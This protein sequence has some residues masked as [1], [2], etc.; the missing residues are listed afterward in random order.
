MFSRDDISRTCLQVPALGRKFK[1]GCL[2]DAIHEDIIPGLHFWNEIDMKNVTTSRNPHT[3]FSLQTS[4]KLKE[5]FD[6]LKTNISLQISIRS[7]N[8]KLDGS[9]ED[10][11]K[12]K[13]NRPSVKATLLLHTAV[14]EL[15]M[16]QLEEC[17]LRYPLIKT[18]GRIANA[19]H[20][21]TQIQYGATATFTF[22][23][24]DGETEENEQQVNWRFQTP[25]DVTPP[26]TYEGA[27]EF[28]E[29]IFRCASDWMERNPL[30]NNQPLGVPIT[31]S[32]YPLVLLKNAKDA[33][34]LRH[35]IS[36]VMA[37]E[38]FLFMQD[39]KEVGNELNDTIKDP[40][41]EKL[42]PL[43]KKLQ[44]FQ[45]SLE[46]FLAKLK[47]KLGEIAA[48]IRSGRTTEDPFRQLANLIENEQFAFNSKRLSNQKKI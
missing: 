46:S 3:E 14:K 19:T 47:I 11:E 45:Q 40:L 42:S 26:T 24:P 48:D 2:Y 18:T 27:I 32:L 33:L 21:V 6:E 7:D 44:L 31:V 41:M 39:Y 16:G 37:S 17:N 9:A 13:N 36:P 8:Y 35:Q 10:L 23:K 34:T 5:K 4:D 15:T 25:D 12:K 28:A 20:V 22:T 30:D 43:T 38:W 29:K 1:L